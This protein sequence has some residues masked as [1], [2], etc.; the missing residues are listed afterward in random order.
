MGPAAWAAIGR[1]IGLALVTSFLGGKNSII[2][3]MAKQIQRAI[4]SN[5][6]DL[7]EALLRDMAYRHHESFR[8]FVRKYQ[9]DLPKEFLEHFPEFL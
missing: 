5:E 1:A 6:L 2:V 7:A 3:V 4:L 9:D 8:E